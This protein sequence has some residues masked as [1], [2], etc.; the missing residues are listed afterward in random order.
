MKKCQIQIFLFDPLWT[1][2]FCSA[3][4]LQGDLRS[5]NLQ[6]QKEPKNIFHLKKYKQPPMKLAILL[7]IV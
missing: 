7:K 6:T 4:A 1:N 3:L 5:E 2:M